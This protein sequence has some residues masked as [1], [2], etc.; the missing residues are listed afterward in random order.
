MLM[1]EPLILA[2]G[3]YF[4]DGYVHTALLFRPAASMLVG[5]VPAPPAALVMV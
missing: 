5:M 1:M 4:V 3:S 2:L